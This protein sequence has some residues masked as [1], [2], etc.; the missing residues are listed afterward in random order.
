[1]LV[2]LVMLASFATV[3]GVATPAQAD[4]G[5]NDPS[6]DASFLAAL[7]KADI[8]YH[9]GPDAVAVGKRACE[10]MD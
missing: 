10:L 4:S 9:S 2:M 3:I 5:S 1:M 8:T 6:R 7:D